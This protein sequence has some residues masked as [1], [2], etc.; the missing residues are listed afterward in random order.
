MREDQK[1]SAFSSVIS[2]GL[3][4]RKIDEATQL[5]SE[6]PPE[7]SRQVLPLFAAKWFETDRDRALQWV[8]SLPDED[9]RNSAFEAIG[10]KWAAKDFRNMSKFALANIEVLPVEF[11]EPL[12]KR[13]GG[14]YPMEAMGW[15]TKVPD[16]HGVPAAREILNSWSQKSPKAAAAFI[17]KMGHKA[18]RDQALPAVGRNLMKADPKEGIQW[19][20]MLHADRRFSED[21][22]KDI[23]EAVFPDEKERS[24]ALKE[25]G[26]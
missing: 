21:Q 26:G 4:N 18:K 19:L 16:E 6:L 7:K 8:L 2:I 3:R 15:Q 12:A 25:I 17:L 14:I 13:W 5:L 11:T 10:I 23:V 20:K 1:N 9:Q 24:D 22:I